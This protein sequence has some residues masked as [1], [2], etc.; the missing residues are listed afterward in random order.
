M[1]ITNAINQHEYP[2]QTS[3]NNVNVPASNTNAVIT[4][5]AG[6]AGVRHC[7]GGVAWSYSAS[8]TG[9]RLKIEDGSGNI[10]FDIDITA[11]GPG[12]VPFAQPLQ[13]TAATALIVTL[14]A[15]G[16]GIQ[17]KVTVLNHWTETPP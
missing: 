10:V 15:G 13:G 11:G 3:T 12:F 2:I 1:S 17:G 16:S 9:G 6:A 7:I 4:Y 5:A 8:P 14:T